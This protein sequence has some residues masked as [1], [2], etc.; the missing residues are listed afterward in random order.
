MFQF[1]KERTST[2]FVVEV[3]NRVQKIQPSSQQER[4]ST[5]V[6]EK[7]RAP[8]RKSE[9][10]PI[11]SSTPP[12]SPVRCG[13]LGPLDAMLARCLLERLGFAGAGEFVRRVGQRVVLKVLDS[14]VLEPGWDD[15]GWQEGRWEVREA[16]KSPAGLLRWAVE[17]EMAAA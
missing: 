17:R 2:G 14:C 16:V 7:P 1:S 4:R 8:V 3:S 11:P 13:Q 12:P 15:G 9:P 10:L 5:L 6:L